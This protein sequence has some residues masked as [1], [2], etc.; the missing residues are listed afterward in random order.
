[1]YRRTILNPVSLRGVGC[2]TGDVVN[3]TLKPA[4]CGEGVVFRR[5]GSNLKNTDIKV[6]I[7]SV[8]DT[9]LN[10]KLSNGEYYVYIAEHLLSAIW[11]FKISDLIIEL[12]ANEIPLFDGSASQ[13]VFAIRSAGVRDFENSELP[14]LN[15]GKNYEC[16]GDKGSYIKCS[17]SDGKLI[18]DYTI[19]YPEKTIGVD[20]FVFDS[21][22][23]SFSEELSCARTFCTAK[24]LDHRNNITQNW[25]EYNAIIFHDDK[26]Q[27]VDGEQLRYTNEATRHKILDLIGD[28]MISSKFINAHFVCYKSG[29]A[30]N[31]QMLKNIL[32]DL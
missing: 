15:V 10:T 11:G 13:F 19:D 21:S 2:F 4:E 18:I 12:D 9:T 5:V 7:D 14:V 30:L 27:N 31:Y 16:F 28:L 20:R 8:H 25:G 1:M 23:M 6:S 24:E 17:P 29:H 26:I 32:N 22:H 3:L